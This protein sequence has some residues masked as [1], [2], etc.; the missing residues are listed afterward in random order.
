MPLASSAATASALSRSAHQ[1]SMDRIGVGQGHRDPAPVATAIGVLLRHALLP[2]ARPAGPVGRIGSGCQDLL[3]DR[4]RCDLALGEVEETALAG[5]VRLHDGRDHHAG[6][7]QRDDLVGIVDVH[8]R[9]ARLLALVAGQ[10]SD[11]R[12]GVERA[13]ER[14][15]HALRPGVALA[16]DRGEHQPR[17]GGAQV[18]VA[19][20]RAIEH[21]AA[22]VLDHDVAVLRQIADHAL[23]GLRLEVERQAAL[24]AIG[25]AELRRAVPPAVVIVHLADDAEGIEV[26]ARFDLQH[27]G[28]EIGQHGRCVGAGGQKAEVEHAHTGQRTFHGAGLG[29]K[30][31][32]FHC[33][34]S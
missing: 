11:A 20:A 9:D 18:L 1:V 34:G 16:G 19:Q 7:E 23:P 32:P 26:G 33:T 17:V 21:A 14:D 31:R 22:E 8:A 28:A 13:A 12:G 24:V 6:G 29:A 25:E 10:R 4:E 15:V 3:A 2:V 27:V 5:A 30:D